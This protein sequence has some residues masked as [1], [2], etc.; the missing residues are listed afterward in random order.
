MRRIAP[1]EKVRI[2]N[3]HWVKDDE[4]CVISPVGAE[5]PTVQS[6]TLFDERVQVRICVGD[7]T[8]FI[9]LAYWDAPLDFLQQAAL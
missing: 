6:G 1:P 8:A 7:S 3:R 2:M 4:H 9:P 5:R